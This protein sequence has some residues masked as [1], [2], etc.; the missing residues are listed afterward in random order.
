[1]LGHLVVHKHA[2]GPLVFLCQQHLREF[3]EIELTVCDFP[4]VLDRL[5]ASAAVTL[6]LSGGPLWQKLLGHENALE[7]LWYFGNVGP[8][9]VEHLHQ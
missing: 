7:V 2:R 1:M 3:I 4:P 5:A 6:F 8:S 9:C